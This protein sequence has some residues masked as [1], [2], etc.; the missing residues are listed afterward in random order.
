MIACVAKDKLT[1]T[2]CEGHLM[3]ASSVGLLAAMTLVN[4]SGKVHVTVYGR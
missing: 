4:G 3:S 2:R 1:L